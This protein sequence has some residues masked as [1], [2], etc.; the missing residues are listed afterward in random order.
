M[1]YAV[2]LS[3]SLYKSTINESGLYPIPKIG[4]SKFNKCTSYPLS[5]NVFLDDL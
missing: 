3:P 1:E 4:L 5:I 2:A